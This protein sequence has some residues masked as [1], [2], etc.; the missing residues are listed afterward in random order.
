MK[1]SFETSELPTNDVICYAAAQNRAVAKLEPN[2]P[3]L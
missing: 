3:G 2:A 1:S